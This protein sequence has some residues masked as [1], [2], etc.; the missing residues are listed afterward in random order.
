[1]R[2]RRYTYGFNR[3]SVAVN[4]LASLCNRMTE[5]WIWNRSCI[6][7]KA[8]KYGKRCWSKKNTIF[9]DRT[10][11]EATV[12]LY[13][14]IFSANHDRYFSHFLTCLVFS[15]ID[16]SDCY[17]KT[18]A[19]SLETV[20]NF[21]CHQILRSFR[22]Y[23]TCLLAR[24]FSCNFMAL[25]C[26]LRWNSHFFSVFRHTQYTPKKC[27]GGDFLNE[28]KRF[29]E[30]AAEKGGSVSDGRTTCVRKSLFAHSAAT[31]FGKKKNHCNKKMS[32]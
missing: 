10:D 12:S 18:M 28:R 5:C 11:V 17:E 15:A 13:S 21:N 16:E 25:N 7:W 27:N 8:E 14:F 26:Y 22:I 1:M 30:E 31:V 20:M 19:D 2:A 4:R 6:I 24:R 3:V 9:S 29:L 23:S 32:E